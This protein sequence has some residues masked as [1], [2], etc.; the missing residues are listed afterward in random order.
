MDSEFT[1]NHEDN[2]LEDDYYFETLE[3]LQAKQNLIQDSRESFPRDDLEYLSTTPFFS[4]YNI[5]RNKWL[6]RGIPKDLGL[7][8]V[9]QH[10][11]KDEE[12]TKDEIG[13]IREKQK[14]S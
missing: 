9:Q 7:K 11:T 5:S 8:I 10:D 3:T 6:N 12:F 14:S 1:Q 13:I 4:N 2:L